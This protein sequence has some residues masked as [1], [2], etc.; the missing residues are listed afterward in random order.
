MFKN[1]KSIYYT[2]AGLAAPQRK[3]NVT[4][5]PPLKQLMHQLLWFMYLVKNGT[6]ATVQKRSVYSTHSPKH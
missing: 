2:V 1:K 3:L 4:F 5:M 6:E